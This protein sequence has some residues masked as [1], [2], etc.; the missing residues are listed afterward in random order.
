MT[1]ANLDDLIAGYQPRIIYQ[2][3]NQT[4]EAS[5]QDHA[6][7]NAGGIP[8]ATG[9]PAP[10]INGAQVTS[11][12]TG[13]PPYTNAGA[14]LQKYLAAVK[15]KVQANIVAVDLWD[16]LWWN[17]GLTVTT[18]TA[19]SITPVAIP[20][21]DDNGSTNGE[22][23][24]AF[25]YVSTAT[26]NGS[27]I[28]NTTMSYTNQSGNSGNTG[29]ISSFPATAVAGTFVP[30]RLDAGDTGV[31]S[32]Q[33]VTLGTSYGGGVIHLVLARH[34]A[35]VAPLIGIGPSAVRE[36]FTTIGMPKLYDSSAIG[37]SVVAN[38]TTIGGNGVSVDLQL[39]YAEG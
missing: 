11:A 17:S 20:S 1:I 19:Q 16:I 13:F 29:T 28:T 26:T 4:G 34:I 23:V 10:G 32:V 33:S 35:T 30:F 12:T 9:A 39:I 15:G 18:T 37:L 31:R 3:V 7:L 38:S 22:G 27:A 6:L 2:K 8:A 14:G 21:R 24:R 36:D 5:G 25:M